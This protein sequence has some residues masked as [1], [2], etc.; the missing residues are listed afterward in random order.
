M[1]MQSR[2]TTSGRPSPIRQDYLQSALKW[3]SGG[4]IEE[5]MSKHQFDDNASEL[6]QYFQTVINW[7]RMLFPNYRKEMRGPEWGDLYNT[8]H[9]NS[10]DSQ[11]MEAN[12]AGLMQDEDVTAKKGIYE[13]LLSGDEKHLNI[14]AFSDNMK[15]EV[16][17]RQQ[18]VCTIC[19]QHFEIGEMEADHITPWCEG[20]RTDINN[21]QMLCRDYNRR[22]GKQ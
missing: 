20:D 2:A 16:Y 6:W 10:Y 11:K 21:C 22:K 15:R 13:Y 14:R 3:I 1:T 8:Y 5:Y 17:E 7:S 12:I 9:N 19:G 18:G 4:N